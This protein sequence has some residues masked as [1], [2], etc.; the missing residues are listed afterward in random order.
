MGFRVGCFGILGF[1]IGFR[2]F[3]GGGGGGGGGGAGV[4][5]L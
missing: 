5:G 3:C 1:S 2:R 4:M